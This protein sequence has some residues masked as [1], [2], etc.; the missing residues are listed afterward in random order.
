M[1]IEP[2][3][4]I[5]SILVCWSSWVLVFGVVVGVGEEG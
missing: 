5:M 2:V 1:A 3:R 4:P